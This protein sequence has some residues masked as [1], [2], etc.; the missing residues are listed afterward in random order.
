[1]FLRIARPGVVAATGEAPRRGTCC[2][3]CAEPRG[4]LG[5]LAAS[6]PA[7]REGRRL[8]LQ[9]PSAAGLREGEEPGTWVNTVFAHPTDVAA[10][11]EAVR[12]AGA[13]GRAVREARK[14]TA[15]SKD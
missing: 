14:Q 3:L 12:F 15:Q 2:I 5:H 4:G 6:C 7:L 8:Y 1:M 11:A 9:D 13:M 10:L